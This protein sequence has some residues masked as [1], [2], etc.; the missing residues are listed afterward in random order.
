[1]FGDRHD[2]TQGLHRI[3]HA[4][5]IIRVDEHDPGDL[6]VVFD[7]IAQVFQVGVPV[8]FGL[9]PEADRRGKGM[10][11]LAEGMG[12]VGGGGHQDARFVTQVPIHFGDGV[13]QA[14][15][16]DDVVGGDAGATAAVGLLADEF[17]C[18]EYAAGVA[19]AVRIVVQR[20]ADHDILHPLGNNLSL[21]DRVANVF[22]VDLHAMFLELFG[23]VDYIPDFVGQFAG[24]GKYQIVPHF[25]ISS[26]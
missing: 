12:G 9:E 4:G 23:Y 3:H 25:S 26:V 17:T 1:M 2:F 16:E 14:V 20:L 5:R 15:E 21:D 11:G 10:A 22:P 7:V 8:V 6:R 19:V 13:S 18:F 24:S